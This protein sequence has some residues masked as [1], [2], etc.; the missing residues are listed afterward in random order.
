MR[1]TGDGGEGADDDGDG[2]WRGRA[3]ANARLSRRRALARA[4]SRNVRHTKS[5]RARSGPR[6]LTSTQTKREGESGPIC[7][8]LNEARRGAIYSRGD[9]Y[10]QV[11]YG[12]SGKLKRAKGN[13]NGARERKASIYSMV[14]LDRRWD[15]RIRVRL[16][17]GRG[18]RKPDGGCLR[19][20]MRSLRDG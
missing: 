8:V 14:L 5:E 4:L 6:C 12:T 18:Q 2:R 13:T 9:T 16:T 20:A 19:G 7:L 10:E 17:R 3:M 1:W 15:T 11:R